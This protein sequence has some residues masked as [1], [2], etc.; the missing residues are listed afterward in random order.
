MSHF[1]SRPQK[2]TAT[3]DISGAWAGLGAAAANL[4]K[5]TEMASSTKAT[6]L[7][8]FYL[9]CV[10]VLHV[11]SPT[12]MEFEAYNATSTTA[13]PSN[14]TWPNPSVNLSTLNM[15]TAGPLI[16][17]MSGLSGLSTDGLIN[18]TL[19]DTFQKTP[20]MVNASVNASTI[21]ANCGLLPSLNYTIL[22]SGVVVGTSING[23]GETSLDVSPSSLCKISIFK[24]RCMN[25]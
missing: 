8:L 15:G 5:Q 3:H 12:I 24:V 17:L 20:Q 7:I 11:A 19:Y 21:R 23:T 9:S 6:L 25:Q 1:L 13:V 14:S 4:W 22:G 2:L 10:S 18:S 16:T